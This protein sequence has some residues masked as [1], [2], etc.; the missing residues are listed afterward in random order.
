[1]LVHLDTPY[2][3][4]TAGDLSFALGLPE[5]PALHVLRLPGLE[6]RLLGASHQVV[7]TAA[8]GARCVETVACLPGREPHLPSTLDSAGYRFESTVEE[9]D[10]ASALWAELAADPQ[11]LVGVFPGDPNAVTALRA[12]PQGW[13]T[14]HAYPQTGELVTTRTWLGDR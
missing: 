5:L 10:A 14:W 11:A 2:A 3:D 7:W 6:L 9:I 8:G 12:D 13:R 1:M 4:T